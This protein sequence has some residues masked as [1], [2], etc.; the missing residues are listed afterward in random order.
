MI[1][2]IA[3]ILPP[4]KSQKHKD[5]LSTIPCKNPSNSTPVVHATSAMFGLSRTSFF[6]DEL[7]F[8]IISHIRAEVGDEAYCQDLIEI[9]RVPRQMA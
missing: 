7:L 6:K 9:M 3:T 8:P 4:A 1:S 2:A 5:L